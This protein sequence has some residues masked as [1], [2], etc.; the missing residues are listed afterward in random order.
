[1]I[2]EHHA[3]FKSEELP[4]LTELCTKHTL[5]TT[6]TTEC[7]CCGE[8]TNSSDHF[9]RHLAKHLEDVALLSLMP[10]SPLETSTN[11]DTDLWPADTSLSCVDQ[12]STVQPT[13]PLYQ[14]IRGRIGEHNTLEIPRRN[15]SAPSRERGLDRD[16]HDDT[17]LGGTSDVPFSSHRF[18]RHSWNGVLLNPQSLAIEPDYAESRRLEDSIYSDSTASSVESAGETRSFVA[19][20]VTEF[21]DYRDNRDNRED[22]EDIEDREDR[23]DREHQLN[24]QKKRL[25]GIFSPEPGYHDLKISNDDSGLICHVNFESSVSAFRAAYKLNHLPL[26]GPKASR[27]SIAFSGKFL[28]VRVAARPPLDLPLLEAVEQYA[29]PVEI[30][31]ITKFDRLK[32]Y[33]DNEQTDQ[34][35]RES[36]VDILS[37]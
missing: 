24:V 22:R 25:K 37:D 2:A 11:A 33:H 28:S 1:M 5:T 21:T 13:W 26:P 29:S 12:E 4:T 17:S 7:P 3:Q 8:T 27:L 9:Y 35:L 30:V 16:F 19:P 31:P 23:E 34:A 15:R 32:Q 10:D 14:D 18:R 20:S 36:K 6:N